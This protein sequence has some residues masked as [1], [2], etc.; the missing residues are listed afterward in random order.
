MSKQ[1]YML[2]IEPRVRT[3]V[4][5]LVVLLSHEDQ[6]N[7][8]MLGQQGVLA[9]L[10]QGSVIIL[11]STILLSRIRN[12]E[13][14]L[15]EGRVRAYLID[16]YVSRG[17][18]EVLNGRI[19]IACSGSSK[20]I[21][22]AQP[23]LSDEIHFM[24]CSCF[25]GASHQLPFWEVGGGSKTKMVNELLEGIHLVASVEATSLAV[26]V[27]IH[28]WIFYDIVAN[29]SG[30]SW[31]FKT[32]VPQFLRGNTE[33]NSH[34]TLVQ[35]L[36]MVLDMAK[37]L[38]FPLP[39]L[40][41][42]HEQLIFG[43]SYGQGDDND[44][45]LLQVCQKFLR[46][47]I[48][49]AASAESYCPE[50]LAGQFK[51]KSSSVKRVGFIG[52]GAMGFFMATHLLNSNFSVVGYDVCEPILTRFADAGGLIAN[53]SAEASKDVD[54][55]VI[56]VVNEDQVEDVLYR[57]L[58][59]VQALPSGASIVLSSTLP[60]GF[61]SQLDR[62]LQNKG[63]GLKLVDTPV[64]GGVKKAA[65]GT[66][67]I[68]ASGTDEALQCTAS[69]LSALSEKLYVIK[70]G[71]GAGSGA[72]M[73]NQLLAGV[74]LTSAAEAMAFGAR[75]GL[76]TRMLFDFIMNNRGASCLSFKPFTLYAGVVCR[77]SSSRKVPV[78][79]TA[80][81]HQLFLAGSAAGWG[82][83][84]DA[85]V[86]KVYQTFTGVKVKGKLWGNHEKPPLYTTCS[87]APLRFKNHYT[88]HPQVMG[89]RFLSV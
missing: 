83:Q 65:N 74:H 29:S 69:V 15:T 4:A 38:T 28:P 68:M 66:L 85:A 80:V 58:G 76:N 42:A 23:A 27:G 7:D 49:D 30:N 70:G 89:L 8:V 10:Q 35:N 48:Q 18:S 55:L 17:M 53:S 40:A 36:G 41:V 75:L 33:T 59:A 72:K 14:R 5:A 82:R 56:M 88:F 25:I 86:V 19:M 9:G 61:V 34:G 63:Q 60:P 87:F 47:N 16:A 44:V 2:C 26:Q 54:V 78:H 37:T 31:V 51:A 71:C 21:A 22:K 62:R 52:L 3:D 43:T 79:I 1:T 73:V 12:L 81:A 11:R 24:N 84:D 45:K 57:D 67:T 6:I 39:L 50:Q 77:E 32:Y 13:K 64:S 20:A 46:V